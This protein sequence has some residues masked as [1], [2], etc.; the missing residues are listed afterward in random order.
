[1]FSNLWSNSTR[2]LNNHAI[3]KRSSFITME[4][5][6]ISPVDGVCGLSDIFTIS[7][8]FL[9]I[10]DS[11]QDNNDPPQKTKKMFFEVYEVFVFFM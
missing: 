8:K 2:D 4:M 11:G 9:L 6:K 7:L 10:N 3:T 1:M 5:L